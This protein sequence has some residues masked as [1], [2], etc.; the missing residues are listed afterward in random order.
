MRGQPAGHTLQATA[1]V[2]EAYLKLVDQS[3]V[4]WRSRAHFFGVA[5]KAMRPSDR[6][7]SRP[8]GG[9]TRRG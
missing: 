1:L 3:K 8:S 7:C 9:Q 5:A 2:H 6:P 4:E